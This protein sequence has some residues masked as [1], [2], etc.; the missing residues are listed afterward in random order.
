M[1]KVTVYTMEYCPFCE[2]AKRLLKQRGV[3][4]KEIKVDT[5]DDAEWDRLYKLSGMK[6]MPQIF[7]GDTLIGG[8]DSLSALDRKDS[9]QSLKS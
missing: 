4:F 8:F 2:S 7:N 5:N 6:T 3:E 1:S 9:L